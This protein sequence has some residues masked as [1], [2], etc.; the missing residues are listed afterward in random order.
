MNLYDQ[1]VKLQ[2]IPHSYEKWTS[3]RQQL[4]DYIIRH[5]MGK[6]LGI[7]GAG[8]AADMDLGRLSEHFEEVILIDKD[9]KAMKEAI[10]RYGLEALHHVKP[11][12]CDLVGIG[13]E[14]YRDYANLL[15]NTLRHS[16]GEIEVNQLAELALDQLEMI[17]HQAGHH[18]IELPE[19]E[20]L[21]VV[22]VHS[23]LLTMLEWIWRVICQNIRQEEGRV[24]YYISQMN[25]QLVKKLNIYLMNHGSESLILG[26]ELER[27]G[28]V[29]AV[30]GACQA[31]ED[32]KGRVINGRL[33]QCEGV[34]LLWPFDE[35]QGIT[36]R[37]LVQVL[38]K[39]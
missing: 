1:L 2:T 17:Y 24:A 6:R 4:T 12:V 19:C 22:G 37:M 3:Y 25:E 21:V 36:Y 14:D 34:R 20:Q 26:C 8:R 11:C 9:E 31:L 35:Q 30:Q 38:E 29:G 15:V 23:Q 39:K 5:S 27:V 28:R 16:G 10:R 7:I 18:K 32:I 13:E 33:K